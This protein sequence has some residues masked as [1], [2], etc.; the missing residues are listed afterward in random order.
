MVVIS[1]FYMHI[2]LPSSQFNYLN[3]SPFQKS[4]NGE[5][6]DFSTNVEVSFDE[7]YL[8][9]NFSC[10]D[11]FYTSENQMFQHNSPL[12]NQEVFEVFIGVGQ[13]DTKTYFEI[14]INPNNALWI[15]K[16]S[17][18]DLGDSLQQVEAQMTPEE[19]GILHKTTVTQNSWSGHLHL[20]WSFIGKDE[21][22]HYRINFYRIR[23]KESHAS[24]QWV[25][26]EQTCDF[27]CWQ[28]TLSG[29]TAAFHRPKRFGYLK[30]N[31]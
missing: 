15:G 19:T 8:K 18:P 16:I 4:T 6:A 13:E 3:A 20:P 2:Y 27:V 31:H 24:P 22:G 1:L 9:I 14:E 28:S 7:H 10:R 11:N 30:V 12:Y 23:S 25:C 17:N 5:D 26:D 29:E 21:E